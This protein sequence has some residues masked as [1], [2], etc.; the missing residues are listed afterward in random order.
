MRL[1]ESYQTSQF[2]N[3]K[4]ESLFEKDNSYIFSECSWDILA[5][6]WKYVRELKDQHPLGLDFNPIYQLQKPLSDFQNPILKSS[7][8][9]QN[10]VAFMNLESTYNLIIEKSKG[11]L[12]PYVIDA[13]VKQTI[14][15]Y[16]AL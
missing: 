9:Y 1:M 16:V 7:L 4:D 5:E 3:M 13:A 11:S 2:D 12:D 10:L 6:D 8:V 14:R 15:D